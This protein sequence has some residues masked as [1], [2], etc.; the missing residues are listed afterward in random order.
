MKHLAALLPCVALATAAHGGLLLEENF[1]GLSTGNL[2][3]QN[4]WTA[5]APMQV[6]TGGLSYSNG[7]ISIDGGANHATWTG[8]NSQPLASK[9][10]ASQSGEVWFSLTFSVTITDNQNRFWFYVSDDADLADSGSFGQINN[11]S[12]ALLGGTRIGSTQTAASTGISFANTE[13]LEVTFFLVG[14]FSKSTTD[15]TAA[16]GDY[17]RMEVWVNPDS[18][19]LGSSFAAISTTGSGITSGIDTF[20]ISALGT[21]ASTVLWDNLRIGTSQADV[22]DVYAIPEPSAFAAF[23][24]AGAL[25]CALRRRRRAA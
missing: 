1:N 4:G 3:G 16:V 6:V 19:T 11:N 8:A 22:L 17:D 13:N 20:A 2:N 15:G 23:A 25:L 5:E 9:T 10:F 18:T 21:G 7:S 12:N 24:G 14:R